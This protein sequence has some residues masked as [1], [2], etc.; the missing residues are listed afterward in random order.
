M[1]AIRAPG[2]YEHDA[3]PG[4]HRWWNGATWS[5]RSC[6]EIQERPRPFDAAAEAAGTLAVEQHAALLAWREGRGPN[7][8]APLDALGNPVPDL[9]EEPEYDARRR[10]YEALVVRYVVDVAT[11]ARLNIGVLVVAKDLAFIRALFIDDW[12]RIATRFPSADPDVLGRIAQA[13]T[14]RCQEWCD[15]DSGYATT[16]ARPS[17]RA[18]FGSVVVEGAARFEMGGDVLIGVSAD[19]EETLR[20]QLRRCV[21]SDRLTINRSLASS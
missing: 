11:G 1:A 20:E 10:P 3:P 16:L 4:D 2:W 13:F 14:D 6:R 19:L 17:V 8:F 18:L 9:R 7:P 12:S 5:T 15:G 21:M